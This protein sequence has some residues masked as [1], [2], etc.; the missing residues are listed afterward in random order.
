MLADD[1]VDW[2]VV[3]KAVLLELNWEI[4]TV[5]KKDDGLADQMVAN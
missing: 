5:V 1:W 4:L 3:L 2:L